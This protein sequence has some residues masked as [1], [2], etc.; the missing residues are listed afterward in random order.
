[1]TNRNATEHVQALYRYASQLATEIAENRLTRESLG[2][3]LLDQWAVTKALELIGEEAWEL[4][5]IGFDLGPSIP[6]HQIAGVRHRLVHHYDGVD[7]SVAQEVAFEDVPQLVVDLER[8]MHKL[9][10]PQE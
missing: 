4:D 7:W 6:L 1:M 2:I 3:N 8:E 9:G 5:K 10:I